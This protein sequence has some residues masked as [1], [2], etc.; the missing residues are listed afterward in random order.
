MPKN[1]I[2]LLEDIDCA[3]PSREETDAISQGLPFTSL[4]TKRSSVSLSGL[5]N[6]I[7]GCGAE[8]GKL[9]FATTNY[10]ERIDPALLRPGRIDLKVE[11]KLADRGQAEALFLRFFPISDPTFGGNAEKREAMALDFAESV[12]Q[13]FFSTAEL[14]GF[15][16]GRKRDPTRA[17]DEVCCPVHSFFWVAHNNFLGL[18]V[19]ANGTPRA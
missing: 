2:L 15:L 10:V 16:L 8:E 19:G 13:D 7:D 11:Y 14:Q 5:L 1:S 9:F 18:T 17:I 6:V 12:P 3:F 4:S